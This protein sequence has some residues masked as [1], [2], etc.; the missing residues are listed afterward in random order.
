MMGRKGIGCAP[1][2][3]GET[4]ENVPVSGI[5]WPNRAAHGEVGDGMGSVGL[6]QDRRG[7]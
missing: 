6:V 7:C 4:Q 3:G 1:L 5:P 2:M